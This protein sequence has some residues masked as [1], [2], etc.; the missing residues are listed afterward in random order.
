[1]VAMDKGVEAYFKRQK[2]PERELCYGLRAMILKAF[3]GISEEMKYGAP[4]YG[5]GFYIAAFRDH[6][7]LGFSVA[8][9]TSQERALADGAGRFMGHVKVFPDKGVDRKRIAMILGLAPKK[10]KRAMERG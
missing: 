3:P 2:K 8:D 9:L 4:W 5:V 7:N 10:S 1:M 6:V